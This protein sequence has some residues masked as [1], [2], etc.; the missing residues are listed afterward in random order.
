MLE[1]ENQLEAIAVPP[2]EPVIPGPEEEE[3]AEEIQG[4]PGVESKPASPQLSSA[5]LIKTRGSKPK[6][7]F[8]FIWSWCA[9]KNV[10]SHTSVV[11]VRK[12][13]VYSRSWLSFVV[14]LS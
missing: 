3:D 8:L 13:L 12:P 10:L 14:E 2:P 5:R 1:L 11:V 6:V 7:S 4:E 9:C